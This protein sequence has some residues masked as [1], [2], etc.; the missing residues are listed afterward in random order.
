MLPMVHALVEAG[1]DVIFAVAPGFRAE[2][3][4]EGFPTRAAGLDLD[5]LVSA[6]EEPKPCG[7]ELRPD[8]KA[9][10]MFTQI[11]PRAMLKPLLTIAHE[12]KADVLLHEEG[13]YG[14]PLVAELLDLPNVAIGWPSPMRA[15]FQIE[16][17]ENSLA[18]LW[19]KEGRKPYPHGGA[20]RDLFLDPCPPTLQTPF[21]LSVENARPLCP[22]ALQPTPHRQRP[23]WLKAMPEAPVVHVTFGTV[24]T[25]NTAHEIYID[26]IE[27]LA[28]ESINLVITTG[29]GVDPDMLAFNKVNVHIEQYLPHSEL[30]PHCD[31]VVCHGGCGSTIAALAHGLPVVILPRGGAVQWRNAK[32]CEEAGAGCAIFPDHISKLNLKQTIMKV[33]NQTRFRSAAKKIAQEISAL[34]PASEAVPLVERLVAER[35]AKRRNG[36]NAT[37]A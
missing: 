15:A 9:A 3:A 29:K 28:E 34:P 21:G 31:V 35:G 30:L 18:P 2:V 11:A 33:L 1:H 26:I 37:L 22:V 20:F 12:W 25:Y 36:E 17:L 7:G 14:A 27:A 13:E 16:R 4:S 19:L 10:R 8:Q 6:A 24:A 23:A 32:A 5:E